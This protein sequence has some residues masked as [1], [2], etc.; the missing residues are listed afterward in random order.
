MSV[1]EIQ[2]DLDTRRSTRRRPARFQQ[3]RPKHVEYQPE[4][5]L[6]PEP[7]AVGRW[8][9]YN[10]DTG[11]IAGCAYPDVDGYLVVCDDLFD[12]I[13]RVQT[14]VSIVPVIA[15]H[16][17]R[18]PHR[19]ERELDGNWVRWT[20]YGELRVARVDIRKFGLSRNG[21]SFHDERWDRP[22]FTSAAEAKRVADRHMRQGYPNS[23]PIPDGLSWDID[24][25]IDWWRPPDTNGIRSVP[26][27][28]N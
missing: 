25:D 8:E 17:R 6:Q 4:Y 22:T 5:E 11:A 24:P 27:S 26:D 13:A 2:I 3:R 16:H 14:V 1:G 12:P 15:S 10:G 9:V 18:Y 28:L 20:Q 23:D 7:R 21:C 19:W